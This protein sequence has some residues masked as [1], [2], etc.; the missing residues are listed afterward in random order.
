MIF[1]FAV[2]SETDIVIQ[3]EMPK[4]MSK[5]ESVSGVPFARTKVNRF[6]DF[7]VAAI[8]A[9]DELG[10]RSAHF[11]IWASNDANISVFFKEP[12]EC[13]LNNFNYIDLLEIA[14]TQH[15]PDTAGHGCDFPGT[16]RL[17]LVPL[18]HI[19]LHDAHPYFR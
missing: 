12:R 11:F 6:R 15:S 1:I 13:T 4:L 7:D 14:D 18:G 17:Y 5:R 10:I 9:N 3:T 2:A 16:A 8:L 19:D